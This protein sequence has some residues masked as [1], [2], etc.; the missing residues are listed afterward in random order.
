MPV[1]TDRN[2]R[3]SARPILRGV[4]LIAAAAMAII[5]LPASGQAQTLESAMSAAYNNNPALL[6]ARARLRAIDERVPQALAGWRPTVTV[7][8][9]L[10]W[11]DGTQ[12]TTRS[13]ATLDTDRS[14]RSANVT[15][16]QPLYRGGR[17]EAATRRAENQVLAE[18]GRLL[19]TEQQVLLDTVTAYSN[20][21]RDQAVVQ[22]T[23]NNVQVLTRQ[24]QATQDRFRVGELKRSDVA[25]AESRLARASAERTRAEGDLQTSR[26]NFMR[27]VGEMPGRLRA[28]RPYR[29]SVGSAR[30]ASRIASERNP[31][32]L[33]ARFEEL[34]A[35]DNI[36]AV[37]GELLP[38]LAIQAQAFRNYDAQLRG[39]L[40]EGGQA[41]LQL[42]VPL[43]QGGAEHARVRE[44]RQ[45]A[46]QQRQ[47]VDDTRRQAMEASQRAWEQ[48]V[49]TRATVASI[50]AQ[51]RAAEIALEGVRSEAQVGERAILDVLNAEQ[52]VLD[53]RVSLVRAQ[54][55]EIV[56][57]YTLA[58]ALGQLT[59]TELK[60]PV[61][62]YDM[63]AY[64]RAVRGQLF[65]TRA[66]NGQGE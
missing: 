57:S 65:G 61:Q 10:G 28:T 24:L 3:A 11:G 1:S 56:A 32:V 20:V 55:D 59:A 16:T 4:A 51:I 43:Y 45:L 5:L 18:R 21:V 44:A 47:Q 23:T 6:A 2:P 7:T 19:A 31:T 49:S 14:P 62:I 36:D 39:G 60:L 17:T 64:Y 41:V 52:E 46:S 8:G 38:T 54:R 15:I 29:A 25:Q 40:T 30:D 34:A 27:V 53:A 63:E 42:T 48:L 26:A 33:A 13:S 12:R 66:R 37:F 35:R 50:Q 58:Q 9:Q 22:L